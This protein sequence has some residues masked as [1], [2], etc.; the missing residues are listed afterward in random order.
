M[1]KEFKSD[2]TRLFNLLDK[3]RNHMITISCEDNKHKNPNTNIQEIDVSIQK[4]KLSM[5]N[6]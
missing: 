6:R 4:I 1:T 5:K 2:R 3:Y